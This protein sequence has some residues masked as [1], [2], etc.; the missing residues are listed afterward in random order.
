[1]TQAQVRKILRSNP[2]A[3]IYCWHGE[4]YL[5][6]GVAAR[7]ISPSILCALNTAGVIVPTDPN[8]ASVWVTPQ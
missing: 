3:A 1:M 5:D 8:N 2:D 4:A 7:M 6:D